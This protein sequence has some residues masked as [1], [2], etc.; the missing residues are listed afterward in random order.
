MLDFMTPQKDGIDIDTCGTSLRGRISTTRAKLSEVFGQPH[1]YGEGDKVT[2][3]W[4]IEFEDGTVA[5]IYDWKRYELGI[6]GLNEIEEY[7]IGGFSFDAVDQVNE[8][9]KETI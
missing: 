9:M 3:E 7:H 1:F 4:I 6:P 5:T 2:T 8:A